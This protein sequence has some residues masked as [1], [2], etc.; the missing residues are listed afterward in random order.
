MIEKYDLAVT[1]YRCT[2]C[3]TPIEVPSDS[4]YRFSGA[5]DPAFWCP[6]CEDMPQ[7]AIVGTP[8]AD[9]PPE[10]VD[11]EGGGTAVFRQAERSLRKRS[12]ASPVCNQ[13]VRNFT[14]SERDQA[15]G[16]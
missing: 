4:F 1:W 14:A 3:R 13:T 11:G 8:A 10:L 6:T 5:E 2:R 12:E 7:A 9:L 16:E 15:C